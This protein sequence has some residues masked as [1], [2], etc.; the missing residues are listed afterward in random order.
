MDLV[1]HI[2]LNHS[3][4]SASGR[5][6]V[7]A[8]IR[9]GFF[10]YVDIDSSV[11]VFDGLSQECVDM[12]LS[13]QYN[14]DL[15]DALCIWNVVPPDLGLTANVNIGYIDYEVTKMPY[16]WVVQCNRMDEIWTSSHFAKNVFTDCGITQN[17]KVIPHTIDE[18][19]WSPDVEPMNI[20]NKRGFC[21]LFVSEWIPRKGIYELLEAWFKAFNNKDDV[22]LI[23]KTNLGM[24]H[25]NRN[26][27]KAEISKIRNDL[28]LIK[29]RCAPVLLFADP[30]SEKDMPKLFKCADVLVAPSLAEGFG[31][32]VVQAQMMGIPVIA[33]DWGG[34]KEVCNREVGYMIDIQGLENVS[35]KQISLIPAYNGAMW[36]K[37]D[38]NNLIDIMR[39]VYRNNHELEGKSRKCYEFAQKFSYKSITPLVIKEVKRIMAS[40]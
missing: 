14:R 13:L 23:L 6:F 11:R 35:D 4:Y 15:N 3:G 33:T 32:S 36:A 28:G 39:H 37:L 26:A 16:S 7:Q 24:L 31:L 40:N 34:L 1:W 18:R 19:L 17:I 38:V 20:A 2:Y 9:S 30:I 25:D 12:F 22:C 5:D 29:D 10:T 27:I 8:L 21:F